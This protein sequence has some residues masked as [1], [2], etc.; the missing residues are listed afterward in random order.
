[1]RQRLKAGGSR[2]EAKMT[3][4]SPSRNTCRQNNQLSGLTLTR[5]RNTWNHPRRFES[6]PALSLEDQGDM[7]G[8]KPFE[9]TDHRYKDHGQCRY[10][11]FLCALAILIP[12][13]ALVKPALLRAAFLLK[14]IIAFTRR[15]DPA[16]PAASRLQMRRATA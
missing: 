4:M 8:E 12:S 5:C 6:G 15:W 10:G 1:M 9:V 2:I 16:G 7:M 3:T 11:V 14:A 13:L